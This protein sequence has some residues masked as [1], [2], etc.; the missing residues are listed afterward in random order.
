M[1]DLSMIVKEKVGRVEVRRRGAQAGF[2]N[3]LTR[4]PQDKKRTLPLLTTPY[5]IW[6]R[7]CNCEHLLGCKK[8]KERFD[9]DATLETF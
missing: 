6:I 7:H 2:T 8:K 1:G 4:A 9:P 5:Q 3:Q